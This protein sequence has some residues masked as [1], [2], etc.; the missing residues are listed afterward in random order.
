MQPLQSEKEEKLRK[1][2]LKHG[3]LKKKK[4]RELK[5]EDSESSKNEKDNFLA[6]NRAKALQSRAELPIMQYKKEFFDSLKNHSTTIIVGETGTGKSTQIPQFLRE[7]FT[8][9]QAHK[10][11]KD[12]NYCVVCTQ[13]RRVAAVTIAQRVALEQGCEVGMEVGYGIRFEEKCSSR[14][15]IKFVTDG[16]LL[17]ETLSDSKLRRYNAIVIDE[18]H[19]RS[20][21]S[22]ILLG[23]LRTLQQK[24]R[25]D[26]KIVIMSATL[27]LETFTNF[28]Q[29]FRYN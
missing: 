3:F 14:T 21:H 29:V 6:G 16:V 26:L 5:R 28:F 1:L 24:H 23:L 25:P 19:E 7:Y 9:S 15:R 18:A 17:R 11:E 22:D 13:P 4:M 27:Q 8:Q 10:T 12:R 20:L 2:Q